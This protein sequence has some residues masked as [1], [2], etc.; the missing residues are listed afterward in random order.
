MV[1]MQNSGDIPYILN[2][3]YR[4]D[5]IP[6]DGI[7]LTILMVTTR[8]LNTL[9]HTNDRALTIYPFPYRTESPSAY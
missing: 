1:S 8:V 4:T 7:L 3:L 6:V 2:I 9:Y 5:G